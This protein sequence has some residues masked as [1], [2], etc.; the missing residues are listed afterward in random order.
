MHCLVFCNLGEIESELQ[1]Y[2]YKYTHKTHADIQTGYVPYAFG[3]CALRHNELQ[4]MQLS[5]VK[6]RQ[7]LKNIRIIL[8]SHAILWALV[9]PYLG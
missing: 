4:S 2:K 1:T 3:A 9:N 6:N 7:L 5:Y 8:S